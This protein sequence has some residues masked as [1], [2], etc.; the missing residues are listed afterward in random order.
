MAD[1]L[2]IQQL[3]EAINFYL[4]HS[5][6]T[7]I[8]LSQETRILANL[9][10]LMIFHRVSE[11]NWGALSEEQTMLLARAGNVAPAPGSFNNVE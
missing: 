10:G 2:T 4:V 1:A 6:A 9:Y 8:S 5:P 11:V 3:E 7:G